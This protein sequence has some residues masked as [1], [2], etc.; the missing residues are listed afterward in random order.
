MESATPGFKLGQ[1]QVHRLSASETVT[2]LRNGDLTVS[3]YAERLLSRVSERNDMVNAWAYLDPSLVMEQA[4]RLDAIP[5]NER[6]PLHGVAV[7]IKDILTTRDMP[8][9]YGSP[10]FQDDKRTSVDATAVLILRSA[11]ALIFGKTSTTEFAATHRGG[12]CR[13]PHNTD[14][15]PGGSSSGSAA[16]V[17]DFQVPIA[18]G[19]QT[20]GSIVRPAAYTG[21]YGFKPTWGAVATQGMSQFS[22]TC[23]TLGFFARTLQDLELLASVFR[24][25]LQR[26]QISPANF[27]PRVAFLK[28][29]AWEKAEPSSQKAW[30]DC[31]TSFGQLGVSCADVVLP[32]EFTNLQLEGWH[33]DIL[34]FEAQRTFLGTYLTSKALLDPTIVQRL[35]KKDV[36]PDIILQRYNSCVG[37]RSE[38]DEFARNYDV[39]ITPSVTGE[40]PY[41]LEYT[42]DSCFN[43]MWT[44]LH[45][46]VIN[47][48]GLKGKAGLPL[49]LSVVGSRYE[50]SKVFRAA[51]FLA[52][53]FCQERSL[54]PEV[55]K[56]Q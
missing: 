21:V 12:S 8:T 1:T 28:T 4:R 53:V 27:N 37:L 32:Q 13:N 40:A 55:V 33:D 11:G 23:D 54:Q 35:E 51:Q 6:G 39:I 52:D 43:S 36:S 24:L 5:A 14:H 17:A 48:P 38:W 16:A 49:G 18:I 50:E 29:A 20:A 31:K 44:L 26:N 2:M 19:S 56:G 15:T 46:P 42:G 25:P 3:D 10:I 30:E 34:T 22:P 47:V 9:R 7:G 41:G 45:A